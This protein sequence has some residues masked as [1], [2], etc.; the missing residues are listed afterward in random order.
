M[1]SAISTSVIWAIGKYTVFS[2]DD[3]IFFGVHLLLSLYFIFVFA[4]LLFF[5]LVYDSLVTI[6]LYDF[7]TCIFSDL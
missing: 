2:I 6:H 5:L 7:Y 3:F 4:F 1:H